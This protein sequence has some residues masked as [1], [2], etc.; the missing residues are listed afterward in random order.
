MYDEIN[1]LVNE[2]YQNARNGNVDFF[3]YYFERDR[4]TRN[5]YLRESLGD[6]HVDIIWPEDMVI[7][8]LRDVMRQIVQ[9]RFYRT[10]KQRAFLG[11]RGI[12]FDYT[13]YSPERGIRYLI[14]LTFDQDDNF[15]ISDIWTVR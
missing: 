14:S 8:Y 1:A 4:R 11:H 13:R 3:R 2:I 5:E 9:S 7:G 6:L 15:V 12:W 10:Y